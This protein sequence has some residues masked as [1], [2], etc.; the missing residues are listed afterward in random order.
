MEVGCAQYATHVPRIVR[1]EDIRKRPHA[2]KYDIYDTRF[3]LL[4]APVS[5]IQS[6]VVVAEVGNRYVR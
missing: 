5:R 1:S 3:L 2:L 6:C 4:I